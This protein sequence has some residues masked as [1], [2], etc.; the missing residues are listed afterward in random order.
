[1]AS[2]SKLWSF[3]FILISGAIILSPV[4][5]S[6]EYAYRKAITIDH[7]KVSATLTNFPV[8]VSISNDNDLKNHVTSANGYDLVFKDGSC[9]K[10]DHELERW[11]GSTGT[12]VAWVR[13]PSLSS[14]ADTVINIWYGDSG[15]TTSQEN[16]TGVW[17]S[18]FKG[19]W[20]LKEASG[21]AK[22]S[23][24][25]SN[26]L[27]SSG[28]V[29]F[30]VGGEIGKAVNFGSSGG[31]LY[32]G[33]GIAP[34]SQMTLSA[35]INPSSL[36]GGHS[37]WDVIAGK[38]S[39]SNWD[40]GFILYYLGGLLQFS[41]SIY[42]I[43]AAQ[44]FSTIG[45]WSY[46]VGS[47]DSSDGVLRLYINANTPGAKSTSGNVSTNGSNFQ[48]GLAP[49]FNYRFNGVIDE[50]RISNVARPFDWI[51]TE[52]RNQSSPSTFYAV[53]SET[54]NSD[55]A[56]PVVTVFVIPNLHNNLTV[57]IT[58]FTATDNVGVTG[59]LVNES[60]SIPSLSD[61]NWSPTPQRQYI[62]SS[63][64]SKTL[65]AWARDAAGNISNSFSATVLVYIGQRI[66]VYDE[67]N[68]L[69]GVGYKDGMVV[70]YIYDKAGN[71]LEE[72]IQG[73][74]TPPVINDILF[75]GCISELCTSPI[76]VVASDPCGGSLTY[77][78]EP[79]DGGTIIGSGSSVVFNPPAINPGYPCPHH[80]KVT[81]TSS[82]S[83]LSTSQTI[84]ISVKIAGDINGDGK[85]NATDKLL[86][87]KQLGWEGIPGSIPEDINCDGKVDAT[88]Q[89]ILSTKLGLGWGCVCK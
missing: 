12:L 57:P 55:V 43:A 58:T 75:K 10:L 40:D 54:Q 14:T 39:N 16:K 33:S 3:I 20:H 65:Y 9:T 31:K 7:T 84:G 42:N 37:G 30:N 71:R 36:G 8:L 56:P 53:G 64:G 4:I 32:G 49:A 62:F 51:L 79:L 83:G 86:W 70:E 63:D 46:V 72:T 34:T 13:I 81:V 18:N 87:R 82:N 66:Y 73:V 19:V 27:S 1:M 5:A 22:D 80:V 89:S 52:Y 88:D 85:V 48:I 69:I 38:V 2:E 15:V 29:T 6:A 21:P 50:V 11:D 23:T 17:D 78:Y 26:N 44:P 68:R 77:T 47:Y 41:K 35:W 24:G 28:D 59:Y 45:S 60:P 25:N 67:L 76:Q 61:P 74:P